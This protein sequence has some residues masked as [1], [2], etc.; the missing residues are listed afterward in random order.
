MNLDVDQ[1]P[2]GEYLRRLENRRKRA[3][4]YERQDHQVS[5]LRLIT[6]LTFIVLAIAV[7]VQRA[8]SSWW[9]LLPA[10]VFVALVVIHERI[11]RS[12]KRARK[13]VAFYEDGLARIEDRWI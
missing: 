10:L 8:I 12:L 11:S 4:H 2:R 7:F 3:A 5:V 6:A 1:D 13:S 9:L